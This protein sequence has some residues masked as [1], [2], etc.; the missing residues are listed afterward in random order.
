MKNLLI[1][2]VL[3]I[4]TTTGSGA[5][6][7]ESKSAK[8]TVIEAGF[9]TVIPIHG[10]DNVLI[11]SSEQALTIDNQFN[12]LATEEFDE[13]ISLVG[14]LEDEGVIVQTKRSID[15]YSLPELKL[16]S[17]VLLDLPASMEAIYPR[18]P[19][20][21]NGQPTGTS[22]PALIVSNDGGQPVAVD[23]GFDFKQQSISTRLPGLRNIHSVIIHENK[24]VCI[25]ERDGLKTTEPL[26]LS[27]CGDIEKLPVATAHH[28]ID[29]LRIERTGQV[30]ISGDLANPIIV[31]LLEGGEVSTEF[32]TTMHSTKHRSLDYTTPI[33][34]LRSE[35]LIGLM[36]KY[37]PHSFQIDMSNE[38]SVIPDSITDMADIIMIHD[39]WILPDGD[40]LMAHVTAQSGERRIIRISD[41]KIKSFTYSLGSKPYVDLEHYTFPDGEKSLPIWKFEPQSQD[42]KNG[43][44]VFIGGGPFGYA[45]SIKPATE[46]WLKRGRTV[47]GV[48]YPG[49]H[50]YGV[51]HQARVLNE[52][53]VSIASSI[54]EFIDQTR[55]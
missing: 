45:S 29:I 35:E 34:D 38:S 42:A 47:Y 28:T 17:S 9:A 44:V 11:I 13:P 4:L 43:V 10:G 19:I 48:M 27:K 18:T 33:I 51:R 23:Y 46:P 49:Y 31:S 36:S 40:T 50:G 6:V 12:E 30:L 26:V 7:S 15:V 22:L 8:S 16:T 37:S 25:V 54:I 41:E 14:T 5:A 1:I 55:P 39:V 32:S 52:S 3:T 21:L 53:I 2:I 24:L 20:I